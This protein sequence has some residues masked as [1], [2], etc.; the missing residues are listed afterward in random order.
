ML[1]NEEYGRLVNLLKEN[2]E[3][4][5]HKGLDIIIKRIPDSDVVG[6]FDPRVLKG[7]EEQMK[8]MGLAP[9]MPDMSNISLE[10]FPIAQMRASMGSAN[11]DVSITEIKTE[12]K[13]IEG[14]NGSI[15]VRIYSPKDDMAMPVVVFFHGGGFIGGS[16]DCVENP[17][18]ALADKAHA[19]VVSVDYRLAPENPF[20]TG[21]TDCFDVVKWI[22]KNANEINVNN[23][24]IAVSGDSAGGNIATVCSMMDRDLGLGMIKYQAL[25]Y[26]TVNMGNIETDDFKWNIEEYTINNHHELITG[27]VYA[28][29]NASGMLDK[30]Y[31]QDKAKATN[32]YVSPLL[33]EDLSRMPETII[34]NAEFDYLRLEC[35]AYGRKLI[36]AGVKT[37]MVRYNGVAHAFMDKIGEYPQAEDCMNEIAKGM[38]NL[39][40]KI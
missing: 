8:G 24:Q 5:N 16:L 30:L 18:K 29:G 15:P 26:P 34:I 25:I 21:I 3:V 28:I 17:C 13:N 9:E 7:V 11:T 22:Y 38:K 4:I 36:C 33:V 20:P 37:K 19:V 31:I 23:S 10:N 40:D 32:P 27:N 35:E 1:V 2:E 39:F 6:D 12:Y 14:E